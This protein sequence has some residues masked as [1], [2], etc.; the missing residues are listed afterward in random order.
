L[1]NPESFEEHGTMHPD[2]EMDKE[3]REDYEVMIKKDRDPRCGNAL[4][5]EKRCIK[6]HA[7][8]Y[9]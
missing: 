8:R 2:D 6:C 1:R 9:P 3:H 5:C 7:C 4:V